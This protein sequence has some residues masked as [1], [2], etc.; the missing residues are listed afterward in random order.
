MTVVAVGLYVSD[1]YLYVDRLP[2][3]GESIEVSHHIVADGGK[4]ANQ[5]AASA[6]QGAITYLIASIGD[7]EAGHTGLTA[8]AGYGVETSRIDNVVGA[9]TGMSSI[10]LAPDGT[11]MVATFAGAGARITT[12]SVHA[13]L[14]G[15]TPTVALL[16][17]E[18]GGALSLELAA[19]G[20]AA[21]VILDPS[22]ADW[23]AGR[24]LTGVDILT[25]NLQEARIL[26]SG[27]APTSTNLAARTGV[28]RVIITKGSGGAETYDNGV[29]THLPGIIV[30]VTDSTGA[31]DAF[32]GALAAALDHG[33][34]F[35]EAAEHALHAAAWS[36]TRP[37]CMASY[38]TKE[39]LEGWRPANKVAL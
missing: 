9:R 37:Y 35:M 29:V 7:D 38:P 1:H 11:Q 25:P 16:Q 8:L 33:T 19:S 34:P 32:N 24:K 20:I 39:Q 36:V 12:E 14:R 31:G 18:T 27:T 22:P 26:T 10:L 5:A 6:L 21:T 30:D 3:P 13:S 23:F 15:L 2:E 28:K 4:A 17:G